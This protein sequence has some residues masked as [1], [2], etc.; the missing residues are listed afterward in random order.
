MF[1]GSTLG[2]TTK[3]SLT[4]ETSKTD[5]LDES[6]YGKSNGGNRYFSI[7]Q[8]MTRLCVK[9]NH[10]FGAMRARRLLSTNAELNE[11]DPKLLQI[12]TTFMI[13]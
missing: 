5:G 4:L 8:R 11:M 9:I 7:G 12:L 13:N 1:Y 6:Q 3:N 2:V 10:N